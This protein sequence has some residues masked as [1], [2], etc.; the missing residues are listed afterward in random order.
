MPLGHLTAIPHM[1]LIASRLHKE[2]GRPVYLG[3]IALGAAAFAALFVAG[4]VVG[5]GCPQDCNHD[6]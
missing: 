3:R 2:R 1:W 4:V 5:M 6:L